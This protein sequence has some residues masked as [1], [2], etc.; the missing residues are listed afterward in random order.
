M[1]LGQPVFR[2]FN[3]I[4]TKA[5]MTCPKQVV[6]LINSLRWMR[7]FEMFHEKHGF[8]AFFVFHHQNSLLPNCLISPKECVKFEH[9]LNSLCYILWV[10][11][12][13]LQ[14]VQTCFYVSQGACFFYLSN[15]SFSSPKKLDSLPPIGC[16]PNKQ[17]QMDANI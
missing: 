10:L 14:M 9:Y 17:P 7:L 5:C 13:V 2:Q 1:F 11:K 12:S 4:S 6:S 15:K 16:V 8:P 3:Q